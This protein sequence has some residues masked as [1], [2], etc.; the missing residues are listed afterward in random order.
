[1]SIV[2]KIK[3]RLKCKGLTEA[4]LAEE[5]GICR[6][7]LRNR[8]DKNDFTR[9]ELYLL[10]DLLQ[11]DLHR[12]EKCYRRPV[13]GLAECRDRNVEAI[14]TINALLESVDSCNDVVVLVTDKRFKL[15]NENFQ[16]S[17]KLL[18]DSLMEDLRQLEESIKD[19]L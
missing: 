1:M 10:G 5:L 4:W 7:T 18:K 15:T 3:S 17:M 8:F 12:I 19:R 14:E 2:E 11:L 16:K 6:Q 9:G 13:R